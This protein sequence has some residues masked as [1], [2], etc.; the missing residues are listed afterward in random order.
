M[1]TPGGL[2]PADV[3]AVVNTVSAVVWTALESASLG[4][5]LRADDALELLSKMHAGV[6]AAP[7]NSDD[8]VHRAVFAGSLSRCAD[9]CEPGFGAGD[10]LVNAL[11]QVWVPAKVS[12][13]PGSGTGISSVDDSRNMLSHRN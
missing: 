2:R 1:A 5:P 6:Q 13:D 3:V 9:C 8:W 10:T 4:D 11:I 12:C 7:N